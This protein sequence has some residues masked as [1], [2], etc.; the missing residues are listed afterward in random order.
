MTY[1]EKQNNEHL[2]ILHGRLVT[3]CFS[4]ALCYN[5]LVV[6][7]LPAD[8]PMHDLLLI[9]IEVARLPADVE[10]VFTSG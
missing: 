1:L 10:V 5:F 9:L 3:R 7:H 8:V 2:A 4:D 6:E